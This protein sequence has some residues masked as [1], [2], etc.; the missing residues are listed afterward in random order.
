M[1]RRFYRQQATER[2]AGRRS[3]SKKIVRYWQ[4]G[5]FRLCCEELILARTVRCDRPFVFGNTL[6]IVAFPAA[7]DYCTGN[8]CT[9]C[10]SC[11]CN[12][13]EQPLEV[14]RE[15]RYFVQELSARASRNTRLI[16]LASTDGSSAPWMPD[17]RSK[18][19]VG[20][21]FTPHALASCSSP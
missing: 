12:R 5:R 9:K 17:L 8:F 11:V 19:K 13:P 21:E 10:S 6:W 20:T 16:S 14:L 4:G 15:K 3:Q 1:T 18:M 2:P 7:P